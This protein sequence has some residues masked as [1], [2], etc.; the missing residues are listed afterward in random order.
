M[1]PFWPADCDTYSPLC[2][3]RPE[4]EHVLFVICDVFVGTGGNEAAAVTAAATVSANAAGWPACQRDAGSSR[5][6]GPAP[7]GTVRGCG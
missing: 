2:S 7:L 5:S 6:Q 1:K 3:T 4:T